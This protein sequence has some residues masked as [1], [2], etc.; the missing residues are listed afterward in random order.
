M[1]KF[2]LTEGEKNEMWEML[3]AYRDL[4]KKLVLDGIISSYEHLPL[5]CD[6]FSRVVSY[7]LGKAEIKHECWI[8]FIHYKGKKILHYWIELP[9]GTKIDYRAKMWFG[10]KEDVPHGLFKETKGVIYEP[11]E[12]VVFDTCE[13]VFKILT[14]DN[15]TYLNN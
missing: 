6:G 7:V 13:L 9:D 15:C 1:I 8:G 10:D 3:S 4:S 12:R 5:E 14:E 11:S 2:N